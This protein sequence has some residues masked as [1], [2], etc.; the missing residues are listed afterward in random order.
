MSE[1]RLTTSE[2]DAVLS[3]ESLK[4]PAEIGI[5]GGARF[6]IKAKVNGEMLLVNVVCKCKP[7]NK[8]FKDGRKAR[9]V[10][11]CGYGLREA[12]NITKLRMNPQ[13][14]EVERG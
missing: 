11:V 6:L 4:V 13:P 10:N 3:A 14:V 7:Y 12:V 5:F 9:Y 1:I 8:E 2:V